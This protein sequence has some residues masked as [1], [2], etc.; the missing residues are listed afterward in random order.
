MKNNIGNKKGAVTH[1]S[2]GTVFKKNKR[3]IGA[4]VATAL[5]LIVAVISV[6]GFDSWYGTY[7]SELFV[8][9]E[10]RANEADSGLT[11]FDIEVDDSYQVGVYVKNPLSYPISILEFKIDGN[12]CN[13]IASDVI[14]ENSLTLIGTD[15][16]SGSGSE[17]N[18]MIRTSSGIYEKYFYV[19]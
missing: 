3:G 14:G 1:S 7:S 13:L 5:L 6:V 17:I 18:L 8:K 12:N 16:V 15:C 9:S 19:N 11:L 10:I 4:V 2:F